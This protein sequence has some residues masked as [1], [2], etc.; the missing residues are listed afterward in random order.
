VPRALV[1]SLYAVL[2]L[3]WSST[4]VVIKIG[5]E[6]VPPLLGAGVR[7]A[8]AGVGLLVGAR[9]L[10]RSLRTDV[11]LAAILGTLP[12]AAAYGLD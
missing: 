9:A 12:F 7:F 8:I 5:L 2:V 1:W 10:G 4:W 11:V 3:V 6:D